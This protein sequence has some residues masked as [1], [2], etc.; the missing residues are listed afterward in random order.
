MKPLYDYVNNNDFKNVNIVETP[1]HYR[2]L[3]ARPDIL[4]LDLEPYNRLLTSA[5]IDKLIDLIIENKEMIFNNFP[6]KHI[7]IDDIL[8][9]SP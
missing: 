8:T 5:Y 1:S 7:V 2:K 9:I 3:G 4:Y 6:V